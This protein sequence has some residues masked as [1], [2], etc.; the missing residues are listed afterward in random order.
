[1]SANIPLF[2]SKPGTILSV[3]PR[4]FGCGRV[5]RCFGAKARRGASDTDCRDH[6]FGVIG[7][8]GAVCEEDVY[9]ICHDERLPSRSFEIDVCRNTR[10]ACVCGG[11][12]F[13]SRF[14]GHRGTLIQFRTAVVRTWSG[15]QQASRIRWEHR[16]KPVGDFTNPILRPQTAEIVRKNGELELSGVV[17][18]NPHN[19]CRPE[20]TL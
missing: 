10:L 2:K 16:P 9:A 13:N 4:A 6:P 12:N 3:E 7:S 15:R 1:V 19:H 17:I 18:P 8:A 20:P 11:D 14:V 5:S